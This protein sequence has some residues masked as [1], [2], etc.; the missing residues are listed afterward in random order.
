MYRWQ[1]ELFCMKLYDNDQ[2]NNLM[3]KIIFSFTILLFISCGGKEEK[4]SANKKE[5]EKTIE[6]KVPEIGLSDVAFMEGT[7]IDASGTMPRINKKWISSGD[8]LMQVIGYFVLEQDEFDPKTKK[9]INKKGDTLIMEAIKVKMIHG[10]LHYIPKIE[11]QNDG[12]E[13][14]YELGEGSTKDS[15][16]FF[17]Q[18]H[19]FPQIINYVKKTNDAILVY[20]SGMGEDKKPVEYVLQLKRKNE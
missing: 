12:A 18:E 16:I 6:E 14:P 5:E 20:L 15:L 8:T 2:K 10:N 7:W 19:D 3:N 4:E 11:N 9:R 13:I 17:N 1:P